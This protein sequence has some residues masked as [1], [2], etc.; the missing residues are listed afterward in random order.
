MSFYA[1]KFYGYKTLNLQEKVSKGE[2]QLITGS[3]TNKY[4]IRN[5]KYR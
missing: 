4:L 1:F 2:E 5:S 3:N